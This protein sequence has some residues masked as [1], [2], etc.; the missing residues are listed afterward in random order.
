MD[1]LPR[2]L[3]RYIALFAPALTQTSKKAR[4]EVIECAPGIPNAKDRRARFDNVTC[5]WVCPGLGPL[6]P[7][8]MGRFRTPACIPRII[9]S[10]E[11]VDQF[12][13]GLRGNRLHYDA[14]LVHIK[15][16]C[17]HAV[18]ARTGREW[19]ETVLLRCCWNKNKG[20]WKLP[21]K[22]SVNLYPED[23]ITR[24]ALAQLLYELLQQDALV[25]LYFGVL[26][27]HV[28]GGLWCSIGVDFESDSQSPHCLTF[29]DPIKTLTE[30]EHAQEALLWLIVSSHIDYNDRD[31]AAH[32]R[33]WWRT[34]KARERCG[35]WCIT[36][37][38][39]KE[40]RRAATRNL[41]LLTIDALD[42]ALK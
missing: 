1:R 40:L 24:S 38:Q 17:T 8:S 28:P 27:W 9:S 7:R 19:N 13:D 3:H 33:S 16:S 30:L 15:K 4:Q 20:G 39:I 37:R 22:Q 35:N 42:E 29:K 31:V 11:D 36:R 5:K 41:R 26:L 6:V 25:R 21:G 10:F 23:R 34:V 2:A 18:M 32:V 14:L 12:L